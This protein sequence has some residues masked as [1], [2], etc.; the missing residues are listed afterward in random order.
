MAPRFGVS[1]GAVLALAVAFAC[2]PRLAMGCAPAVTPSPPSGA[3][4]AG[5]S[6]PAGSAAEAKALGWDETVAAARQEGKLA[7]AGPPSQSWREALTSFQQDYPEIQVEY[8]GARSRDYWPRVTQERQG[9]QF[10][11]DVFVIGH[12][13]L[14]YTA[15]DQG[16]LEPIRPLLALPEVIDGS[17][18]LGG[19]DGLFLDFDKQY[20][21]GFLANTSA[22]A[23]VN[24]DAV[25]AT[26]LQSL[27]QLVDPPWRGRIVVQD[28]RAGIGLAQATFLLKTYGEPYL[29]DLLSRQ[30]PVV[31]GDL[32][33]EA[34]WLV[35]GRY[36]IAISP[37]P[38]Y[39]DEF[40]QQGLTFR[41]E[42]LAQRAQ[43]Y[44]PGFGGIQYMNRAPHPNAS[45]V[46]INWLLTKDVQAR[47]AKLL[48][49]NSRRLDVPIQ[50]PAR[51]VDPAKLETY[52]DTES[53]E[54]LTIQEQALAIA[55]ELIP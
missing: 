54:I 33:Q 20:M 35:R 25:P 44:S 10:D 24:R 46:F 31:T 55:R 26:D 4:P 39:L 23:Y 40:R 15:K 16:M 5:G 22:I 32:R 11:H 3:P 14:G 21:L 8:V 27:D 45:K 7:L 48:E 37:D 18:W 17:K 49:Q 41:V 34:E 13:T 9:G 28:P 12:D 52:T 38:V 1:R 53:E 30:E 43:S 47:L 2:V 6:L 50:N 29:R 19:L 36:P 42:T 51:A